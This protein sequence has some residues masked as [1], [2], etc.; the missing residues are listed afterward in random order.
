MTGKPFAPAPERNAAPILEVLRKEFAAATG[1][2]EIGSG[3]GQHAVRFGAE[4]QHLAWQTSD[5]EQNHAGIRAWIEDAGLDNVLP[6]LAVDVCDARLPAAHYDGVFSANTA[7]IMSV[8]AVEK[9]FVLAAHAL[10]AGGVFC[11]YGPFREHGVFSAESNAVFDRA[12][13]HQDPDMGVRDLEML[14]EFGVNAGLR[15]E[16]L[17][18]MPANNYLAVWKKQD[19][20]AAEAEKF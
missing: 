11:L 10:V 12:L 20:P 3:T 2:L 8:T 14:D 17:Y 5:L 1:V 4:L 9:M 19:R 15:R 7:H 16:R 13:R 18:A 6:P